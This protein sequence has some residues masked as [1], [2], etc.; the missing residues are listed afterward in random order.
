MTQNSD[1]V[2]IT[3]RFKIRMKG[4]EQVFKEELGPGVLV[5]Q[6]VTFRVTEKRATS[7][8]FAHHVAEYGRALLNE[9]FEV[10]YEEVK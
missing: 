9:E 3:V 8:L 5:T 6:D 4:V 7:P 2:P 1:I 10:L